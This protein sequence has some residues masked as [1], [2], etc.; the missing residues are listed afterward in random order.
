[1]TS[2]RYARRVA[3]GGGLACLAVLGAGCASSS[4]STATPVVTVTAP[5]PAGSS[6]SSSP[7]APPSTPNTTVTVTAPPSAPAFTSPPGISLCSTSG[8]KI[9]LGLSQGAA[10][11]IYQ[12][13]DFTNISGSTCVLY[14]YPG[15]SVAAGMP[16]TQVGLA[17]S[18]DSSTPRQL[19]TLAPG[20]TGNALLKLHQA[21]FFP[22]AT[23]KPKNTTYLQIYPPN[24]TTPAYIAYSFQTCSGPIQTLVIDAARPGTGG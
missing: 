19:V 13:I 14:G 1:M 18:E 10:G 22:P 20:A 24:Q 2:L 9:Y 6:S 21:G 3:A 8:L 4:S 15:V 7:S 23:C 11:T 17:A 5:T 16:V 12:V